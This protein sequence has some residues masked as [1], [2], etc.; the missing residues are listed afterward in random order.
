M[1]KRAKAVELLAKST[2]CIVNSHGQATGFCGQDG[3]RLPALGGGCLI[4]GLG[5][6][7]LRTLGDRGPTAPSAGGGRGQAHESL[8]QHD[9]EEALQ[10]LPLREQP[11]QLQVKAA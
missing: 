11:G 2:A 8:H 6:L 7:A 9:C 10:H 1:S 3:P 4:V 5:P